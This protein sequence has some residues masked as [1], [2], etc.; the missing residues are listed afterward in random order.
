MVQVMDQVMLFFGSKVFWCVQL[1]QVKQSGFVGVR[2]FAEEYI[3]THS[4][5]L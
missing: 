4:R 1:E 3:W 5:L 2:A